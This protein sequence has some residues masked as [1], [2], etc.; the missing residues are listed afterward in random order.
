MKST[1]K[2]EPWKAAQPQILGAGTSLQNAYTQN[3]PGI[4]AAADSITGLMPSMV[5]KYQQG[6]AGTNAARDY[7]VGVLGGQYLGANPYLDQVVQQAGNDVRNQTLA[8]TGLRGLTG[9]SSQADLVSRNVA[10]MAS[11]L[12]YGDYNN[13]RA[14][15]ATAAGQAPGIAA[16]D[17]LAITPLLASLQAAQAPLDA[18][19]Q[20]AGSVSGLFGPYSQTRQSSG[21]L[22]SLAGMAGLGLQAYGLGAFGGGK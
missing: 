12:R 6:D 19:G 8:A 13:E 11:N 17:Y 15:M 20:Y 1:T 3:A 9:G 21:L 16:A 14:R 18:A 5:Q 4:Q 2:T 7:N 22:G 10:N